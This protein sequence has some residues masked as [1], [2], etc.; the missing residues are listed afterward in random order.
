M[1]PQWLIKIIN[2]IYQ[3]SGRAIV[4]L[5]VFDALNNLYQKT[6]GG[7]NPQCLTKQFNTQT[8]K[9]VLL[10]DQHRGNG[11]NADDF[12]ISAKNFDTALDYYLANN[13]TYINMGDSEECWKNPA[14]K[15][16]DTYTESL[17]KEALFLQQNKFYKLFGNHDNDW[18]KDAKVKNYLQPI[19][20]ENLQV[21]ESLLLTTTINGKPLNLF[22]A[23]GH[24]GDDANDK[25]YKWTKC[26]VRIIWAPI[27]RL[28]HYNPN[29][30]AHN[31]RLRDRHNQIMYEWSKNKADTIFISGHTHV[32]VFQSLNLL[33][34]L[35]KQLSKAKS[36]N[37]INQIV[38]LE[39]AI[40]KEEN[41]NHTVAIPAKIPNLR[42]PSYYNT[43][44]CCFSD[45]DITG[46]EIENGF[47]RLVKW[48]YKD[49][50]H[51]RNVQEQ[52]LL[53]KIAAQ[54]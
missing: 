8:D 13:F 11:D 9:F 42:K 36:T 5:H 29:K 18:A 12:H 24:Q 44:C 32:A 20:G 17:K 28:I 16:V 47:I 1:A 51:T 26:K 7:N 21:L 53:E 33:E 52:A 39:T 30:P 45:G 6:L 25:N 19:F 10:S 22:L 15:V 35:N 40:N 43:G 49:G 48:T 27:E 50:T 46:I 2:N 14:Q 23:H 54:L 31:Y 4:P 3:K 34:R 37:N 41:K 38:A